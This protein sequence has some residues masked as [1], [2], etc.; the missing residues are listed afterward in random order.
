MS[1]LSKYVIKWFA[2]IFQNPLKPCDV[3]LILYSKKQRAGK[4]IITEVIL[5]S[6]LSDYWGFS[7][8]ISDF[9]KTFNVRLSNKLLIKCNEIANQGVQT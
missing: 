2:D 5:K 1:S 7:N 6:L 4:D 9:S 3:A 8:N